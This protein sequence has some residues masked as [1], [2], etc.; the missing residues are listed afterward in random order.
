MAPRCLP[1]PGSGRRGGPARTG[2]FRG[3]QADQP[4][5]DTGLW[6][7]PSGKFPASFGPS[8]LGHNPDPALAW[9]QWSHS[10]SE[11]R[12]P[13]AAR[14]TEAGRA[15]GPSS[16]WS[17]RASTNGALVPGSSAAEVQAAIGARAG[18]ARERREACG[19]CDL[20]LVE[21][22]D[23]LRRGDLFFGHAA[24]QELAQDLLRAREP[25]TRDR[26]GD[27]RASAAAAAARGLDRRGCDVVLGAQRAELSHLGEAAFEERDQRSLGLLH[28]VTASRQGR[29][30]A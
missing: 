9:A 17:A 3:S 30:P 23:S 13:V 25:A 26:E 29:S 10:D 15:A 8:V 4:K 6:Q 11:P 16:S 27:L 18:P 2:R 5:R 20:V 12:R 14:S 19:A 28:R 1:S 22:D 24:I 7:K 21:I